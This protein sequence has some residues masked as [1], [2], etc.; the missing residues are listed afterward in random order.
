MRG[1]R[2]PVPAP[3]PVTLSAAVRAQQQYHPGTPQAL[4]NVI[5]EQALIGVTRIRRDRGPLISQQLSGEPLPSHRFDRAP[6]D[7]HVVL[8]ADCLKGGT[9]T[10]RRSAKPRA[11]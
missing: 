10:T 1:D 7:L 8:A 11:Q 4:R 5:Q 2:Q 6:P 3:C 9:P